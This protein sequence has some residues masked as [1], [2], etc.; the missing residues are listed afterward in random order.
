MDKELILENLQKSKLSKSMS[1]LLGGYDKNL[2][3]RAKKGYVGETEYLCYMRFFNELKIQD[4]KNFP[5]VFDDSE[6]KRVIEFA[7]LL[8]VYDN[9]GNKTSLK[10]YP[11]QKF[12]IANL[13][14]WRNVSSNLLRFRESYISV[15]RRNG[16]SW[17]S[18][19]LL[20]Y[21]ELCS[22]FRSER[23]ICFSV[24]KESAKIVFNQF[25]SFIDADEDL[26][27]LYNVSKVNGN[28][29]CKGTDNYVT[30]FSGAKDADGFQSAYAVGDEIALMDGELYQLVSDG[31][32]N[33]PQAQLVGITTAGFLL[34]GWC[35]R[36]YKGLKKNLKAGKLQD[37]MF[38]MICEPDEDD[39][40]SQIETWCKANPIL[41]FDHA[42][43][44]KQDVIKVYRDKFHQAVQQGGRVMNSWI[45]KQ[46]NIWNQ[47]A[48]SLICDFSK[49][50]ECK[51]DFTFE[52]VL[53][54]Y[55]EWYLGVD[56]AQVADLNSVCFCT[57][58]KVG[59]DGVLL[60]K[61][62]VG[63]EKLYIHHRNYMPSQTLDRHI[64]TDKVPYNMYIDRELFLTTGGGGLR[65]DYT[66]I[67]QNIKALKDEYEL[68]YKVIAC[69]SY[70]VA[71]ISKDLED[72][73]ECL[74]MQNQH[75]KYLSPYIEMFGVMVS[76]NEIAISK[77]DSEIFFR[78]LTNAVVVEQ[79]DGYVEIQKPTASQNTFYRIDAC[80]AMIDAIIA[81]IINRQREDSY[82][83]DQAIDDMASLYDL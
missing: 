24:K 25:C 8:T 63:D 67:Y 44:L 13:F 20:H 11:L 79:S 49:L 41:F 56:L 47:K 59:A 5:Y 4:S 3:T 82:T 36:R 9:Q 6:V 51:Y 17:I 12:I 72:I 40:V 48:D 42:G 50:E 30:V 33:L 80:D 26:A 68:T 15:A 10:L 35:H 57:W 71:S 46:C 61:D 45:T 34:D 83:T 27:E 60:D 76:A 39:D 69:D 77:Q 2:I 14:G 43:K 22:S 18:S 1:D 37:S 38:V 64:Q 62:A 54:R 53:A 78:A 32:A 75:R 81:P 7:S 31:Q 66:E 55:K 28:A 52:D 29:S 73:T 70:G 21:F 74:I 19:V 65:T 23:A 16:K 58:I